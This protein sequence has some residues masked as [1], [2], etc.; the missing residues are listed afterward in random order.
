MKTPTLVINYKTYEASF[1]KKALEIAKICESLAKERGV[2]IGIAVPASE[3]YIAREVSIPVFAQHVD[4]DTYG[5]HT[6]S[7]IA[8]ALKANGVYGSLINHSEDPYSMEQLSAAVA[9]CKR[10]GLFSLVCAPDVQRSALFAKLQ[11]DMLAVEPPE[12]IGS[13]IS[14]SNAKPEVV[15]DTIDAVRKVNHSVPVLCG[16]GVSTTQDVKSALQLGTA[17][18][19]LASIVMKAQ[20]PKKVISELLD[21]F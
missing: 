18:V 21:G 16:A 5:A 2:S 8:E 17:G 14:V 15:T 20:D 12:L 3:L 7:L 13:G 6:G 4:A 19:L 10:A 11:P 1:G 9:A